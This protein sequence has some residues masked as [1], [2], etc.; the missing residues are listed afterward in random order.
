MYIRFIAIKN[1]KDKDDKILKI[2]D[3]SYYGATSIFKNKN[4]LKESDQ[5]FL[6]AH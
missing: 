2:P 5:Q 6:E 3:K 4:K 1:F